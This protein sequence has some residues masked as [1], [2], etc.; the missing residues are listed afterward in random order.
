MPGFRFSLQQL[1][2]LRSRAEDAARCKLAKSQH[3]ADQQRSRLTEL[4]QA[5]TEAAAEAAA[6]PGEPL[7]PGMLLNANL[8]HARLRLLTTAQQDRVVSS[9]T[10]EQQDRARLLD[11]ARDRQVVERLRERQHERYLLER[12]QA[13]NRSTEEAARLASLHRRSA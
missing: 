11:T 13:D 12:A 9:T 4:E 6:C 2:D 8:H 5:C 3:E 10:R 1:L 7:Q